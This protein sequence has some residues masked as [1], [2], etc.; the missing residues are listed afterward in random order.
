MYIVGVMAAY[1]LVVRVCTAQ[2]CAVHTRTLHDSC[3]VVRV[4]TAQSRAFD[5]YI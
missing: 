3:I 1:L 5:L 2:Y 4:Y